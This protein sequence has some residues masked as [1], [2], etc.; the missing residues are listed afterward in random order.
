M[1]SIN[2]NNY[3]DFKDFLIKHDLSKTP[4]TSKDAFTHTRMP[5][6]EH[7]VYPASFAISEDE[8]D[9]FYNLYHE[10]IF[11]KKRMEYLTERQI[12]NIGPLLVDFDFRYEY[13]V[14]TKQ[15]NPEHI[16]DIINLL[17]LEELKQFFIFEE[18]KPFDIF[19]ME[20]PHVNRVKEDNVT[21]DGIH[22]YFGIQMEHT[23]QLML[24]EKLIEK[25]GDYIDLPIVNTWDKV[26]DEGISSGKTNWT[27]YGSRKPGCEAY[28]VTKH[29]VITYD[30]TDGEFMMKEKSFK[31]F[32]MKND[33]KRLC[34][35]Y[36][37]NVKF[38]INPKII[39][40]YNKRLGDNKNAR[41]K[42]TA[43]K[44][45]IV[46][47]DDETDPYIENHGHISLN[48]ITNEEILKKAV[49]K[50]MSSL[51]STEY[52][53]KET[54]EYTQILP[55]KYYEPG[56]HLLNRMVAFALKRTDERLFLSW[57]M[58]RSKASDFDYGT[59]PELYVKWKNHFNKKGQKDG[60]GL[61]RKT[62][63]YFAKQ[64][65]YDD[66]LKVKNNTIDYYIEESLNTFT[67]FDLATVLYN[68]FKDK[69]VCCS[70]TNKKWYVFKNH[71]WEPDE[72]HS[73]RLAI[74]K[75][76]HTIYQEKMDYYQNEL[77]QFEPD[78]DRKKY[79][80]KKIGLIADIS[81]KLK[82]TNDKNNIMREA[83]ELF[84]DK[85]FIKNMDT[86]LYLMCFSNGVVDFKNKVFRDG[87]PTDY[88]T[89]CTNIPY[90][91]YDPN[92]KEQFET[93][94]NIIKF[95]EQLF[96][97]ESLN[98]YMWDHLSSCLI[99]KNLN[100]TFNI[101][102][103]SGSNGKSM[104]TDLMGYALGEYKD[105]VPITLVTEKRNNIG[106]TS[107]EVIRLKGIRY[108]VMQEP[109]KGA[110]INEGVMKELTGG[111]PII[112]RGLYC[113][114]ETFVPQFKLVVC[115]N[116][117]FEINSNDDG[118]WRR[119][120]ICD[121]MSKFADPNEIHTHDT[122]YVFPK[123]KDLGEKLKIWATTFAA[124][125][126]KRVFETNGIVSD[127]DIVLSSSNRYRQ[128]QDH[129]AAFISEM[130]IKTDIPT[131]RIRKTELSN[132]FKV[133]FQNNQG[134]RKMPKGTELYEFMEKRYGPCKT[135]GWQGLKINY[136]VN[137]NEIDTLNDE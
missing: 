51:R 123:D 6:I 2:N 43:S 104:L 101:Y 86:N 118:T 72:G 75:E 108:A 120:R 113:D 136:P 68:M 20:K 121:Y 85:D 5:G 18:N 87:N 107:P 133:W 96:P 53:I 8:E 131:D 60:D 99:G 88:I 115:T 71:R 23:M 34:A 92:D 13:D 95:M 69:Y 127:C 137:E 130:V 90:I 10:H 105:T 100:Q 82:K 40:E 132:E 119:I 19:V 58:L 61:T 28:E 1:T 73:L 93:G 32:D 31:E 98:K 55:A 44:T 79:S 129:I 24:R 76:L 17:Y 122:Q 29:F 35:R 111:D 102:R 126:V 45:K 3:T 9:T 91:E 37:N 41:I 97:V 27:L 25:I 52:F 125:L 4:G 112:A 7:N 109:S 94:E 66:Y 59:I 48:D 38:E 36:K 84:Y 12:E 26:L 110:T 128:G 49:D 64:D 103:G 22:F 33:L 106:G 124:M 77:H 63:M 78:D 135:V 39:D 21:K 42:K 134:M 67:E 14:N 46:L 50:I 16:Q 74:S 30:P 56:S 62:I 116:T 57:V 81:V 89:K 114:T 11:I 83:C 70:I 117:L 80:S 65:A 15:H 47:L 54:H